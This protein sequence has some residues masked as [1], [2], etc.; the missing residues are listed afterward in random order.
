M[1][2]AITLATLEAQLDKGYQYLVRDDAGQLVARINLSRVRRAH[3]RCADLG[4]RVAQAATG[5]G[6][7]REAVRQVVALAFGQH[8]LVRLEA[9]ARPENPASVQVLGRTGFQ[10]FG[11]STQSFELAGAWY[12][13]LHFELRA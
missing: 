1:A 10:P 6:V 11:R 5:Q 3:Y 4:Y 2:Q 8:Q 7:A 13:L 9:T 12:D